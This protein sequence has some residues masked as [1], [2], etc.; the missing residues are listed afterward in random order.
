MSA[1]I[2]TRGIIGTIAANN[3]CL[4]VMWI[5]YD[6]S[7]TKSFKRFIFLKFVQSLRE[8]F[9]RSLIADSNREVYKNRNLINFNKESNFKWSDSQVQK[10]AHD[11]RNIC[12]L[13]A[14]KTIIIL[15]V[16]YKITVESQKLA[17][18]N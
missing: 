6:V 13:L 1:C 11:P 10:S 9:H 18:T 2:L 12:K 8:G 15:T 4:R 5:R 14:Q 17:L 3:V 7:E 16:R